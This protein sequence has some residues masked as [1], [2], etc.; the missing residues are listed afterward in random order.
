MIVELVKRGKRVGVSAVSH[1]VID[2]LLRSAL[3]AA[4]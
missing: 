3:K 1:K 2:N 4:G